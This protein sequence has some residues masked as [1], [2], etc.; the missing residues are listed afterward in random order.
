[1]AGANTSDYLYLQSY[2]YIPY[3]PGRSQLAFI[4]FNLTLTGTLSADV[5]R[6]VGLGDDN[7]GLFLKWD[8]AT[9]RAEFVVRTQTL[10][11]SQVVS[12]SSWNLDK[13]NGTGPS[14]ITIDFT[15]SQ[16][17]VID[18]QALYVGR[19]RM[20]FDVGGEIIYAHEFLNANVF[21]YPY[22]ATANLPIRAGFFALNITGV[23]EMSLICCSVASEGGSEDA[24][25]FGYNFSL[26]GSVLGLAA[27]PTL[28]YI[29]SLRP[30]TSFFGYQNRAKFVLGS[31]D[32]INTGNRPAYFQLGIGATIISPTYV[33]VN[34]NYSIMEYDTAGTSS[35]DPTLVFDSGYIP[36]GG[37]SKSVA[38]EETVQSRYPITLDASGNPRDLGTLYMYGYGIGG[39]TD[40]YYSIRWKEIR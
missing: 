12:E 26:D 39:T 16:I 30:L 2:E 32:I 1:M 6:Y 23:E 20:G 25:R 9:G 3:Q 37:G 7:N 34:A 5:D 29:T 8:G 28:N 15:K 35:I 27:G 14:G 17:L 13:M 10:A 22:I 19:V 21:Q 40:I 4:T 38:V 33:S 31:I 18:F 11:G 36:S 24:Q